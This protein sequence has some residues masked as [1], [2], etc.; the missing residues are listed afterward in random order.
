M[1]NNFK[2]AQNENNFESDSVTKKIRIDES[3]SSDIVS[4]V[5]SNTANALALSNYSKYAP[6]RSSNLESPDTVLT[7]H[8]GAVYSISFDPSGNF[9]CSGSYD[10]KICKFRSLTFNFIDIDI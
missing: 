3:F 7:G 10:R 1:F 8:E 2:R 4:F 6:G 9:L 5:D